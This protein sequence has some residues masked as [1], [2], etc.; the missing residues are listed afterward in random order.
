MKLTA[1]VKLCPT[2]EQALLLRQTVEQANRACNWVS[3][4]SWET[5]TFGQF[6]LHKLT[7]VETRSKFPLTAQVVVRCIAKVADAYKLDRR[8]RAPSG[9]TELSHLTGAYS[10]GG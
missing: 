7:Y 1:K 8:R 5:K 10:I 2:A 6:K 3:A 9:R 4:R